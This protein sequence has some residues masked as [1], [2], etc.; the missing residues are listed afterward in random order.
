MPHLERDGERLAFETFGPTDGPIVLCVHNLL[1]DRTIFADVVTHVG[2]RA[3]VVLVDLRGHGESTARRRFSMEDLGADLLAVLDAV[4]AARA[5]VVG[6]S[7]GAAAAIELALRAPDRVAALLL[8]GVN[9][10]ASTGTDA[11]KNTILAAIVRSVGWRR[12]VLATARDVLFGR[13]FQLQHSDVV[14][15][16]LGRIGALDR[17][18]SWFAIRCWVQRRSVVD[19]LAGLRVPTRIAAGEE[20]VASPPALA[21]ET[22]ARIPG[23]T[24]ERLPAGHTVPLEQPEPVARSIVTLVAAHR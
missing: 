19:L 7:L 14:A 3:R 17:R 4:G 12:S 15:A 8:M 2:H 11:V 22:Q 1:T 23:A 9:P 13:T 6:V 18:A 16:W 24:L 10:H 20:D 21:L 5:V